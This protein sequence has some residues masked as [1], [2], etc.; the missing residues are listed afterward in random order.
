MLF[1]AQ[2][3]KKEYGGVI[4]AGII[5]IRKK[6]TPHRIFHPELPLKI[7][8]P[9]GAVRYA[10]NLNPCLPLSGEIGF[11]FF[12]AAMAISLPFLQ[13]GPSLEMI[14][15]ERVIPDLQHFQEFDQE[16]PFVLHLQR[17]GVQAPITTIVQ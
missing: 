15:Q 16:Q 14:A 5:T 4:H 17:R 6:E 10:E 2:Q 12:N 8:P 3:K 7:F 11:S 9:P 1:Q 13:P